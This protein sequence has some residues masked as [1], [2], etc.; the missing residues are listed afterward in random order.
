MGERKTYQQ[1]QDEEV[2]IWRKHVTLRALVSLPFCLACRE[3]QLP[4]TPS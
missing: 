1:M 2:K 4:V 3:Q